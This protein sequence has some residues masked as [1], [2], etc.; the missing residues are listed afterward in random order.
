MRL[1][2]HVGDHFIKG[3]AIVK[4]NALLIN[5]F[6]LWSIG[7]LF[8]TMVIV[9]IFLGS[10]IKGNLNNTNVNLPICFILCYP[11]QSK[12]V[13]VQFHVDYAQLV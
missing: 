10:N 5:S 3:S 4:Q 8:D 7:H 6:F 1:L 2:L 12:S 11:I 9:T 13:K